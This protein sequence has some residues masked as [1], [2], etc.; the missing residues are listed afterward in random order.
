MKMAISEKQKSRER[1][2]KIIATWIS[3]TGNEIKPNEWILKDRC[4]SPGEAKTWIRDGMLI[5]WSDFQ[6]FKWCFNT[7]NVEGR[8]FFILWETEKIN[9]VWHNK[10]LPDKTFKPGN[11]LNLVEK[12]VAYLK[13]EY[14]TCWIFNGKEFE[15][16]T[17]PL[18]WEKKQKTTQLF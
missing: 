11:R 2:L 3:V 1:S 12:K 14:G 9:P 17:S 15:P 13:L 10:Q 16:C 7:F 6:G 5:E 8:Y 18:T 4:C